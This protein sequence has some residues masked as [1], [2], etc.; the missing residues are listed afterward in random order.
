MSRSRK[1]NSVM[2]ALSILFFVIY[3]PCLFAAD[4]C[5]RP[6]NGTGTVTLPPIGCDYTSPD[7][8]YEII[9]GLPPG[10]TI[11]LDGPLTDFV[12]C[13][14]QCP[15]C[16]LALAPGQCETAGGTLGG[17]VHCFEASLDLD[18]SGTGDLYG[19]TRHLY[20]PVFVEV[21]T[22]PR[23]PGDPVQ[24]FS[25]VMYRLYGELF[26]DPDF[27]T[28]RITAGT[29]FGLPG[30]GETTL[31]ELPSGD[32]NVDSFFDITY[33]IEF[34][35]CPGSPLDGYAGTTTGTIHIE[36]GTEPLLCEPT[37]DGS[38][39]NTV[40][41]PE[42]GQECMPSEVNFDPATGAI[43]YLECDCR[44]EDDCQIDL[45]QVNP[46]YDCIVPDNGSG[47]I[48]MPPV[49]CD[50]SSPEEV[51]MIIDGLP[52]GTTIEL[53][54]PL[55]DFICCGDQCQLCS[56]P[57][58]PGECETAGGTLGGDGHCFEATLDLV[59]S[60]TGDLNGYNRHLYIP[61]FVE[62]H[63]ASRN[64]GDP[65]QTFSTVMYRLEGELFGDPDFCTFRIE[66][67]NINGLPS[68]GGTTLTELPSGDFA[69]DS[70]FDITYQIEFEGCPGS[71]LQDYMGT[72]TGT[73]RVD[74]GTS[75]PV[76]P[77]CAGSCDVCDF[78][79]EIVTVNPDDSITVSCN[80]V[81]DADLNRDGI[82]NIKD[83]A[84]MATQWLTTRDMP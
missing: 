9:D 16:S 10:T 54:G 35:G 5:I 68:P 53:D 63:T 81:P 31:T 71:P 40:V 14:D 3:A 82:V 66:A 30:P 39:C 58:G 26:G 77:T 15:M 78:C 57:L 55:K 17:N 74:T 12:C 42:T 44:N 21:H 36:T 52:P 48:T 19:Y 73:I 38:A 32:F 79:F 34:E 84:I 13:G 8:V 47:T 11:E 29:D 43:T 80:C 6:D 2:T 22:A 75:E 45:S 67:G 41:C 61:V 1:C 27:C 20:I 4:P 28:L 83:L 70:F 65:I 62:V 51:Y 24:M 23:N 72:T 59:V 60:G 46:G 76:P 25:A 7:E 18:V 64:P 37:P 50:Y 49:G 56:L 33:Q 69:V